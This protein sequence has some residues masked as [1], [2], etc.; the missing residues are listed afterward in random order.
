MERGGMER[1][2]GMKRG[3]D[4][5]R[6]WKEER[7][8]EREQSH[9]AYLPSITHLRLSHT[10]KQSVSRIMM[11]SIRTLGWGWRL[12]SSR[13]AIMNCLV[14]FIVCTFE[15]NTSRRS[16]HSHDLIREAWPSAVSSCFEAF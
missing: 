13:K 12:C 4:R 3:E 15:P 14:A 8:M 16:Q 6:A 2:G 11:H 5:G 1:G 7:E 10:W 9:P